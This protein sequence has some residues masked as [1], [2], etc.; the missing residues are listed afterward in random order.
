MAEV[1]QPFTDLE[2]EVVRNSIETVRY[3]P[4]AQMDD[5][6]AP[7]LAFVG[8]STS[9][10][11]DFPRFTRI[12][13]KMKTPGLR[14]WIADPHE[15]KPEK[16][17]GKQMAEISPERWGR[18]PNGEIPDFYRAVAASSGLV[19][20]TSITEGFGNVAPE[21]AACGAR[22][23][24]TNVM[25]LREAVVDGVTGM[26]FPADE[27]DDQ[28]AARLDAWLARPHDPTVTSEAAK[29]EFSPIVMVDAYVAIYTRKEQRPAP[30]DRRLPPDSAEVRHLRNHL[31]R[32]RGWRAEFARKAA[33]DFAHG[34]YRKLALGVLREAFEL[35]PRQFL[36]TKAARQLLSVGKNLVVGRR[37]PKITT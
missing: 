29:R 25:G 19:L 2:V 35:A 21:A 15:A 9:P 31:E 32:Q 16:F 37:D 18:V 14:I 23:A 30:P 26:L 8:R 28:V 4:P 17:S 7:I 3:G 10:E 20:I 27:P 6:Q 33:V 5:G 1:S 11:K 24:A 22:V 13:S 12:A 36:T 34:G